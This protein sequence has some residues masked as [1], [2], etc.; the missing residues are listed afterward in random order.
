MGAAVGSSRVQ[1]QTLHGRCVP[2]VSR[3]G[4]Q[5]EAGLCSSLQMPSLCQHPDCAKAL[6]SSGGSSVPKNLDLSHPHAFCDPL[7]MVGNLVKKKTQPFAE[8]SMGAQLCI[9]NSLSSLFKPAWVGNAACSPL[10]PLPCS[11]THELFH[12]LCTQESR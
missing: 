1:L 6:M 11:P 10:I 2:I 5:Q 4:R 9:K 3:S 12:Y 8:K 7:E